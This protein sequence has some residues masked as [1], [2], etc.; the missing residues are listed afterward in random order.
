MLAN[1][2][3]KIISL[4]IGNVIFKDSFQMLSKSLSSLAS[5][6]PNEH[7][8]EVRRFLANQ[9]K[10]NKTRLHVIRCDDDSEDSSD[11]PQFEM[12]DEMREEELSDDDEDDELSEE[13]DML[14]D[15]DVMRVDEEP[16]Q[17]DQT[18][19]LPNSQSTEQVK[20]FNCHTL[21]LTSVH[22]TPGF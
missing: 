3:E 15:E 1:T 14:D 7:F 5:N 16:F 21:F 17:I 9:I 11:P 10:L 22:I 20:H 2:R 18:L 19:N 6:L 12:N 4:T 8:M 13:D